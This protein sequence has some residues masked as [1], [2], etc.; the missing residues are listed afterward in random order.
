M[1]NG[2][3]FNQ[4]GT[5]KADRASKNTI[6]EAKTLIAF[7]WAQKKVLY[8]GLLFA[9]LRMVAVTPC[10][11]LFKIVVDQC[12]TPPDINGIL[13]VC[14]VFVGLMVVHYI[15]SLGGAIEIAKTMTQMMLELRSDIFDKLQYLSFGYLDQQKTGRL[16]SKYAFDTQRVEGA[17]TSLLV[18]FCPQIIYSVSILCLLLFMHWQ[19]CL[20]LLLL[21]PF[22]AFFRYYFAE[23]I[24]RSNSTARLAQEKLTGTA[25]ELITALRLVRSFGEEKQAN[26]Q[27]NERSQT[28]AQSKLQLTQI[29]TIFGTFTY[30]STQVLYLIVV[31][32]GA[33]FVIKGSLTLGTLIV[34]ISGMPIIFSPIQSFS[35]YSDQYYLGQESYLSIKELLDAPYV[36]EWQ[37]KGRIPNFSGEVKFDHVRFSYASTGTKVFKDFNLIIKA[38]EHIAIAGPSGSGKSTLVN[39]LLGLYKPEQ[40]FIY[41]DSQTQESLDMRW[42]RKQTAVV[43]QENF[44]LSGTILENIRFA[45][46]EATE[47]EVQ[48]AARLANAE[49]F[50][51]KMPEGYKSMLGERGVNLSGGQRQR[52]AIARAILRNPRLLILDEPTSAL[53]YESEKL[54]QEA[55]ERLSQDRTVITI[56]HRLSTIKNADRIIVLKDGEIVEQGKFDELMKQGGYFSETLATQVSSL[57]EG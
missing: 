52:I 29:N 23:K 16:L 39:L 38:G 35:A 1:P 21:M 42:L 8:L 46:V 7:M 19:L 24:Q 25:S 51:L 57:G 4:V 3:G 40:G 10:P 36:E 28:Y 32:G 17:L 49:P 34:F 45:R 2:P 27:L 11:W 31:A 22:Y 33:Y 15:F 9:I 12:I 37:G 44:L 13:V 5:P 54:I 14:L 30:V 50:I 55:L 41:L 20:V 6:V 18:S 56:A 48:E 53:D 26:E 43:M 47:K